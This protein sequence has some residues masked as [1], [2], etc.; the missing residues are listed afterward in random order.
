MPGGSAGGEEVGA[1]GIADGP[2]EVISREL[3]QWQLH[4]AVGD[5][6]ERDINALG[7][8]GHPVHE[9]IHRGFVQGVDDGG[10]GDAARF[11]DVPRHYVQFL[12]GAS[13]QIDSGTF[14]GEGPGHRTSDGPARPVDQGGLA[15][16]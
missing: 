5:Q 7:F 10:M 9:G 4:I 8:P 13:G 14:R 2:G 3:H 1:D 16:E 15:A 6:V 12:L 11:T